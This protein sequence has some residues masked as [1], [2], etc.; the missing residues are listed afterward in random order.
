MSTTAASLVKRQA[1]ITR[2]FLAELDAGR[3]DSPFVAR[4]LEVPRPLPLLLRAGA[5]A[6]AGRLA[7]ARADVARAIELAPDHPVVRL[8]AGSLLFVAR[9]Y[10]AA[11]D[12]L[13]RAGE[14]DPR[15]AARADHLRATLADGLGWGHEV[16]RVREAAASRDP[17]ELL[18]PARLGQLH[19]QAR[20][21]E[22]AVRWLSEAVRRS[23]GV[24]PLRLQL[25]RQQL[26]LGDHEGAR[27]SLEAAAGQLESSP[28][29]ERRYE[30]AWL[31]MDLGDVP[32]AA[33]LL[34]TMANE[35]QEPARLALVHLDLWRGDLDG[36]RER[37]A[38]WFPD[39]EEQPPGA[40]R[41]RGIIDLLEARPVPA[42]AWL[43]RGLARDPSDAEA[44][45]WR[46]EAEMALDRDG[47]A[48]ES[49]NRATMAAKGYL[50]VAWLVRYVLVAREARREREPDP[51]PQPAHRF[52]EFR[53]ALLELGPE[54]ARLIREGDELEV[55]DFI[56]DL[57]V[58]MRG[59]RSI[60]ATWTHEAG[61]VPV[62]GADLQRFRTRTGCRHASRRALQL[63]RIA[64]AE[65]AL[66][67]LDAVIEAYPDSHLPLCH[68]GELHYWMGD[69][70]RGRADLEATLARFPN[71]RWA[72]I[73][74]GG[75]EMH[76]GELERSLQVQA[77][78]VRT[79]GNTEG[80][81]VYV[82]RG[83]ALRRLGRLDEAIADL[84]RARAIYLGRV[85]ASV[86][87][88]LCHASRG[89]AGDEQRRD[90]LFRELRDSIPALLADA[91]RASGVE[92]WRD[93]LE[94][95]PAPA[96]QVR[97]CESALSMMRGN[98]SS[99][100]ITY[101]DPEGRLRHCL[102]VSDVGRGPHIHDNRLLRTTREL[103]LRALGR[104]SGPRE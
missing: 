83:E 27:A 21:H 88:H 39:A 12:Q 46:A 56:A 71:T 36:A 104:Y 13:A 51:A 59:N 42:L 74:L 49:L 60:Y 69:M 79:M 5:L 20:D 11:L 1:Q 84:E 41:A 64:S 23:P 62:A 53:D 76:E 34:R 58:R 85:S 32:R 9:D 96:E 94:A 18:W 17:G 19:A 25:A 45:V 100:C 101:F 29:S 33:E 86:N 81:A 98:R 22:L 55:A 2:R 40:C 8:A 37:L 14:L 102:F 103:I 93:E 65:R 54:A 67:A 72:W 68:R 38:S 50:F 47:E 26:E 10:A 4:V 82:Y 99:T 30:L 70:E 6:R 91:A 3:L 43:E 28:D 73:G 35:G 16:A 57:L 89:A 97:V 48:H 80:P 92:L 31:W 63:I 7:S 95:V 66:G 87:L 61:A 75:I 78:G 52:E 77:E 24:M 90:D 15:A 44:W